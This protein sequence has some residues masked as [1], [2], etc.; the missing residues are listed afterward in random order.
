MGNSCDQQSWLTV[1]SSVSQGLSPV[2]SPGPHLPAWLLGLPA[3]LKPPPG[4]C[5]S[6]EFLCL[7]ALLAL[8][9]VPTAPSPT[10]LPLSVARATSCCV[11][12][13]HVEEVLG[14]PCLLLLLPC[15]SPWP[16]AH[17]AG[18]RARADGTFQSPLGCVPSPARASCCPLLLP[19][20]WGR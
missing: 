1:S 11:L 20:L 2:L 5:E 12:V 14:E 4:L 9:T 3:C 6:Q 18:L 8:T 7:H 17:M 19:L 16:G 15:L 13:P 10:G